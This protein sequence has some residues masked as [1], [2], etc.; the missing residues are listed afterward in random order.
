LDSAQRGT[1]GP[2]AKPGPVNLQTAA[3]VSVAVEAVVRPSEEPV[4]E[5]LLVARVVAMHKVY[6]GRQKTGQAQQ[7]DWQQW[8]QGLGTD[9]QDFLKQVKE[10]QSPQGNKPS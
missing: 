4:I 1:L 8:Q 10:A 2:Y 3:G 5:R 7:E 9:Y 6:M